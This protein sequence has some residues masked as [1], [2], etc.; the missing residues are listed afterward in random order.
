MTHLGQVIQGEM[1]NYQLQIWSKNG[2]KRPPSHLVR[3]N[4]AA[5]EVGVS[6]RGVD[7][8]LFKVFGNIFGCCLWKQPVNTLPVRTPSGVSIGITCLGFTLAE[9]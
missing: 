6:S 4:V 9:Y 5:V 8:V 2:A 3:P 7:G 1:I